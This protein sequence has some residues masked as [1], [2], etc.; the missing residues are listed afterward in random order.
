MESDELDTN[1]VSKSE[2]STSCASTSNAEKENDPYIRKLPNEAKTALEEAGI[3]DIVF[4]A[5]IGK[6]RS[7]RLLAPEEVS[8]DIIT[9]DEN[10][11]LLNGGLTGLTSIAISSHI[12]SQCYLW[13][14]GTK[15]DKNGNIIKQGTGGEAVSEGTNCA[16]FC[17]KYYKDPKP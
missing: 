17:V 11:P 14:D 16:K 12:G 7:I 4:I 8:H 1:Y 9:F 2:S 15:M 6:D 10:V 13:S 5:T 3:K